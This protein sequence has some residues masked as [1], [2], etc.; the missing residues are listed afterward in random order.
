M[1]VFAGTYSSNRVSTSSLAKI[2]RLF[3]L[4]T[5]RREGTTLVTQVYGDDYTWV[6]LGDNRFAD[7]SREGEEILFKVDDKG[8]NVAY[9]SEAPM[10]VF[11][12]VRPIETTSG[13]MGLITGF[14]LLLSGLIVFPMYLCRARKHR[15]ESNDGQNE[16]A[17]KLPEA[18]SL[19]EMQEQPVKFSD[20]SP[21]QEDTF[22]K[23][24]E[25]GRGPRVL[26][27]R[28]C[29]DYFH[30][31]LWSCLSTINVCRCLLPF[32]G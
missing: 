8:V 9:F 20:D 10:M 28:D 2:E 30:D 7:I 1:D 32:D 16:I 31:Y 18:P 26:L 25:F 23:I 4:L 14:V 27:G 29:N 12:S 11:R 24:E 5:L 6:P 19:G 3:S 21:K 15:R 22:Q 17:E 13:Q